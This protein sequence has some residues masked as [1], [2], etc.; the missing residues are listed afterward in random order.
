LIVFGYDCSVQITL[1]IQLVPDRAQDQALRETVG[2]FNE[3]ANWV[4]GELF[5]QKITNKRLAQKRVYRELRDRFALTAQMAILVIHRV[6]EAY[7][8][9]KAVRP[10]FRK[11]AAITYDPR[12]MRFIGLDK[13]NLWTLAGR[14]VIPILI[15]RYQVEQFTTAAKQSDL[16]L[17]Q[18]GK[19]FLLVTVDVPEATPIP[20]TDFIGIDLGVVNIATD[21]DGGQMPAEKVEKARRKYGDRRRKLQQAATRRSQKGRRPR[22]IRRKLAR[23]HAREG[24]YKKDVNHGTAK[25]YVETAKGTGRGIALENLQGIRDRIT[26]R[27]GDARNKLSSWSFFQF[28]AFIAYK[29]R[30]AGVSV[31]FVDPAYTSQTCAECGHV[32]RQNRKTQASFCCVACGHRDHADRNGARNIRARA[33]VMVSEGVGTPDHA[34]KRTPA[35]TGTSPRLEPWGS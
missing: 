7:K 29:A 10:T 19:W 16:V 27:G 8:R 12:V 25:A 28:R 17:R 22:S 4:A 30:A 11:H 2:R 32:D 6:C 31:V 35:S 1:Q 23:D 18:D 34:V 26:A 24:R 33:L 14:L 3:A 9:D 5:A 20:V 15:G 13:V 21:S